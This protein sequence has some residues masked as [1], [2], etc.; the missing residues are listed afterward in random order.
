MSRAKT[1]PVYAIL[2]LSLFAAI[3]I[4][5]FLPAAFLAIEIYKILK[6]DSLVKSNAD[7]ARRKCPWGAK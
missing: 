2:A 6:I 1:V 4:C 3:Y 5:G 7:G